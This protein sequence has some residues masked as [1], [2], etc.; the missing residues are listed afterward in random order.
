MRQCLFV[1]SDNGRDHGL[2]GRIEEAL[3]YANQQ[4]SRNQEQH[5]DG[6]Y[7]YQSCKHGQDHRTHKISSD[8]DRATCP[9]V[10]QYPCNWAGKKPG[11]IERGR[12]RRDGN[13]IAGQRGG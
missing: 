9:S 2:S 6:V 3:C 8:Q 12:D 5:I 1:T 11:Q 13:R 7:K 4:D 10:Y